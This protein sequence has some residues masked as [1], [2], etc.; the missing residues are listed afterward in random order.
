MSDLIKIIASKKFPKIEFSLREDGIMNVII[1]SHPE[2][3]TMHDLFETMQWVESL[4]ENQYL[5]LYEGDFSSVDAEVRAQ[6][7][8]DNANQ[9]TIADAFVV[10]NISDTMLGDFYLKFNKPVKPTRKFDNREK[11]IEWLLEQKEDLSN[12]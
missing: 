2:L 3:L 7:S 10:Q 9:Y 6:I 8:S 11:A 4:G 1:L 12:K 5:N